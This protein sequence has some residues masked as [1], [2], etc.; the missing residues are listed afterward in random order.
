MTWN[1][2][3]PVERLSVAQAPVTMLIR[4]GRGEGV[5]VSMKGA[6]IEHLKIK[7]GARLNVSEGDGVYILRPE[8]AH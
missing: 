7:D 4:S 2:L 6:A 1:S 5:T 3:K 8:A